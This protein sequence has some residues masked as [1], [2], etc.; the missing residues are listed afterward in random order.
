MNKDIGRNNI[1]IGVSIAVLC[2]LVI[3][4]VVFSVF[5]LKP[6][7]SVLS[8][9]Q[10][11]V[12]VT[13]SSVPTAPPDS[14]MPSVP[15]IPSD[16]SVPSVPI[17]VT[18]LPVVTEVEPADEDFVLVSKYIPDIYTDLKYATTDNIAGYV[19]YDFKDAYLRYGTVKK[20]MQVQRN[21][22]SEGYSLL[23]WD[24]FRPVEAQFVLWDVMPDSR[25]IADPYTGYSS[26]SRGNCIDVTIVKSDGSAVPMPTGFDDFSPYSGRN[27]SW[28]DVETAKNARLLENEM[29]DAG[30]EPYSAEWWHYTDKVSYPVEKELSPSPKTVSLAAVGDCIVG[31]GYGFDSSTGIL[32]YVS[33][34]TPFSYFFEK[35]K[36]VFDEVDVS[37]ANCENVF[38]DSNDRIVKPPQNNG[39][40]WFKAPA[41]YAK[42]FAEGSIDVVNITNNHTMDYKENGL[43]DT[44]AALTAAGVG[45]FGDEDIYYFQVKG[46]TLAFIGLNELGPIEEGTDPVEF[47]KLLA[48]LLAVAGENSDLQIVTFHWGVERSDKYTEGQRELAEY[49]IDLGADLIL[50]HHPHVLQEV[51]EYKGIPIAYSLGNFVYGGNRRNFFTDT[52]IFRVEFEL[53][54]MT[55]KLRSISSEEIPAYISGN[56]QQNNFQPVL[57]QDLK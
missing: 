30:F 51:G 46:V 20:L 36:Y 52:I 49:A 16:S 14:S 37:V 31:D 2:L 9:K 34:G 10:S 33:R 47:R 4:M 19:I 18:E 6:D 5:V 11:S 15:I 56:L 13:E 8:G 27:Y 48:N 29:V 24:A 25:Y 22:R 57:L 43:A 35:V 7:N 23:I 40:F 44:K 1:L 55:G 28:L 26:H 38:T 42:I 45:Y 12:P 41:E 39:E 54:G 17:V 32:G 3:S 53:D 21:L 50:G